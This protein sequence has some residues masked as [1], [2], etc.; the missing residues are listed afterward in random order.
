MDT[1]TSLMVGPVEEVLRKLQKAIGAVL[2]QEAA[3]A[4]RSWGGGQPPARAA[5]T[6]IS[7]LSAVH[8]SLREGTCLRSH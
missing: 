1:G 3:V 8:D 4:G 5:R 7:P 2:I 6:H